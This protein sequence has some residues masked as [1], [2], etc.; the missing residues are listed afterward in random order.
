MKKSIH[1]IQILM[2]CWILVVCAKYL[3]VTLLVV[4]FTKA[5][6]SLH[7]G[8]MEYI[9]LAYGPTPKKLLQT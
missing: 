7:K 4:G 5:F 3:K 9:F 8:K 6:D 1:N 2:I